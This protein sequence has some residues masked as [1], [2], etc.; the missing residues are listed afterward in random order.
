MVY[1][2]VEGHSCIQKAVELLGLG[3]ESIRVIDHDAQLRMS[4]P[5]L[6][7]AIVAD[8]VAGRIPMAVVASAGTVNTGAIDPI[9]DIADICE[10]HGVWLHVDGAYGAAAIVASRYHAELVALAR[11]DSLALDPH[12]WLYVPVDAGVVLIRD[13]A[14]MRAAF[15][16]VP[17]YLRTDESL[18]GV[19]GPPWFSEYGLEQTR[20]FRA[21]KVWM[22]LK[23][24]GLAGYR[25]T[26]EH[27]LTMAGRLAEKIG[28]M[29]DLQ[30]FAPQKLSIVCF[31]YAP[32]HLR[33]DASTLNEMNRA[34]LERLQQGGQ[35]FLSST[36]IEGTFWLRACI[37]NYRTAP[38]DID[39]L[40]ELVYSLARRAI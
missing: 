5:A 24:H 30:L 10:R 14:T 9:A 31:R 39:M 16:L 34:L 6:E 25:E 1:K 20:P 37:V 27:D 4:P 7:A 36:V 15:S 13:A 32:S 21:L 35:A 23:H 26:I 38:A 17:P 19:G 33:A 22:C 8:Q 28:E 2:T 3:S 11:C 18:A 40:P 12:K 29:P